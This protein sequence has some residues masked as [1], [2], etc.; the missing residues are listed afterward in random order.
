M[1]NSNS[2]DYP[3]QSVTP[4][5][6]L[7]EKRTI[8]EYCARGLAMEEPRVSDIKPLV[9][10]EKTQQMTKEAHKALIREYEEKKREH[11]KFMTKLR[12]LL[13]PGFKQRIN[14]T[15]NCM[16]DL[17]AFLEL[18]TRVALTMGSRVRERI[19]LLNVDVANLSWRREETV[20]DFKNR[21]LDLM[22][23]AKVLDCTYIFTPIPTTMLKTCEE[24][25]GVHMYETDEG[26]DLGWDYVQARLRLTAEE[27]EKFDT[28]KDLPMMMCKTILEDAEMRYNKEKNKNVTRG[29]KSANIPVG[30]MRT[31]DEEGGKKKRRRKNKKND[32]KKSGNEQQ[33]QPQQ[34][35][36][37][38]NQPQELP[39]API[40]NGQGRGGFRGGFRGFNSNQ[41]GGNY[42][43]GGKGRG[44]INNLTID[45]QNPVQTNN[46]NFNGRG[47]GDYFLVPI[48]L[49][50]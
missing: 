44:R 5:K 42:R 23:Y 48:V 34:Q 3:A 39:T 37:Q 21:V 13:E 30:M 20:N 6:F 25:L 2:S 28:G 22:E 38:Q 33:Q 45:S 27:V 15:P 40:Y 17:S 32:E 4:E 43:G 46:S 26:I 47:R 14:Q 31:N 11:M 41:R 19:S 35:Q 8:F 7:R 49:V 24:R 1:T 36:Q 29:E 12:D 9:L 50:S 16:K 10:P 18:A